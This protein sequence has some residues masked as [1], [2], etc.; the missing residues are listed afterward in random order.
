MD[1]QGRPVFKL[2]AVGMNF[3]IARNSNDPVD[4][5]D[6]LSEAMVM[7]KVL[8]Y[9]GGEGGMKVD[10]P[11]C[12]LL[13]DILF[14]VEAKITVAKQTGACHWGGCAACYFPVCTDGWM[15]AA[16][17]QMCAVQLQALN[18]MVCALCRHA[19]AEITYPGVNMAVLNFLATH[20]RLSKSYHGA[21]CPAAVPKWAREAGLQH[22]CT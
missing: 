10:R 15:D 2:G 16:S 14:F 5:R 18:P 1:K 19:G 20:G 13:L 12:K 11:I 8:N 6:V 21:P 7:S 4:L 3:C 17:G 9:G 22:F